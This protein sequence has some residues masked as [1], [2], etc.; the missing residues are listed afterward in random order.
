[1]TKLPTSFKHCQPQTILTISYYLTQGMDVVEVT[2][3]EIQSTWCKQ[4]EV[5]GEAN[6]YVGGNLNEKLPMI[7]FGPSENL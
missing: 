3:A 4:Y 5:W 7:P 6:T 1:M 2:V